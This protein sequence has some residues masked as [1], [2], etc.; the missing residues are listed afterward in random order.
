MY[1]LLSEEP[2]LIPV[3]YTTARAMQIS[4]IDQNKAW[5]TLG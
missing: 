3:L 4:K 1:Q 5:G 2:E